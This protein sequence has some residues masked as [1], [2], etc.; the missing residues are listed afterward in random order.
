LAA[1]S[2]PVLP[3]SEGA[4]PPLAEGP[5]VSAL[6]PPSAP[7]PLAPSGQPGTAYAPADEAMAMSGAFADS[8]PDY[9]VDADGATPWVWTAGD[10]SVRVAEAAPGG[11]RYY[12]YHPGESQPYYVQDPSYGYGYRNGAL[13]VVYGRDGRP[14]PPASY[15]RYQDFAGRYYARG[16]SL[17][18]AVTRAPRRPVAADNWLERRRDIDAQRAA[19]QR[20]EASDP[21]WRA[22]HEQHASAN[23]AQWAAEAERRR[24]LAQQANAQIRQRGDQGEIGG[25]GAHPAQD[26]PSA[27]PPPARGPV[28]VS[29]AGSL[30]DRGPRQT[31][32]PDRA[33]P[34]HAAGAPPARDTPPV[35]GPRPPHAPPTHLVERRTPP[36]TP[37]I[38]TRPPPSD[39]GSHPA[40]TPADHA[41]RGAPRAHVTPDGAPP[42]GHAPGSHH[43]APTAPMQATPADHPAKPKPERVHRKPDDNSIKA[44]PT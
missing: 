44:P 33:P 5:P 6:P 40:A 27:G 32:P 17:R 4:T 22:Y 7:L 28:F 36:P 15:A 16:L 21:G 8:P 29:P 18:V 26:K 34:A 30:P 37:K 2:G 39:S 14:L 12:Y 11:E 25:P 3:L 1:L 31:T 23:Q 42:G 13:A 24:R 19:S 38:S 41:D 43:G 9:A 10:N 35:S 20:R